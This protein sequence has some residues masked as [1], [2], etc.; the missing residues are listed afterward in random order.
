MVNV[1]GGKR[2]TGVLANRMGSLEGGGQLSIGAA[3]LG[4]GGTFPPDWF[5]ARWW[6]F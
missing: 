6:G 1:L 5:P 4:P 2:A 3:F